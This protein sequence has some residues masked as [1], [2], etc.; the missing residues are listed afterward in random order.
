MARTVAVMALTEIEQ[1]AFNGVRFVALDSGPGF[2]VFALTPTLDGEAVVEDAVL[3]RA[4]FQTQGDGCGLQV[5]WPESG[6]IQT[7]GAEIGSPVWAAQLAFSGP[8]LVV[9]VW[10]DSQTVSEWVEPYAALPSGEILSLGHW[11]V[12]QA[13]PI[14]PQ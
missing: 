4:W 10:H 5:Q 7:N 11:V 9:R 3:L 13:V 8:P 6:V 2:V 14:D 1:P 12:A